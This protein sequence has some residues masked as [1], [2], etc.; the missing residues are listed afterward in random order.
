MRKR[1]RSFTVG[2]RVE[3][4]GCSRCRGLERPFIGDSFKLEGF[5]QAMNPSYPQTM[6]LKDA[7][8][9]GLLD[10]RPLLGLSS[11]AFNKR[12]GGLDHRTPFCAVA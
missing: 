11:G 6:L 3:C 5:R 8:L 10:T 12:G 2:T 1:R 4:D 7:S 9:T